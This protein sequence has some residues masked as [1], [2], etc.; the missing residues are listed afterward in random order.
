MFTAIAKLVRAF[1][2]IRLRLEFKD[3]Y[4]GLLIKLYA[5]LVQRSVLK[6]IQFREHIYM[7]SD[8]TYCGSSP[9]RNTS[10]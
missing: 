5:V 4:K 9:K 8:I 1:E 7:S 6:T 10:S 3:D 2:A